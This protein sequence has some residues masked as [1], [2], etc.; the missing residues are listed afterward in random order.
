MSVEH[1]VT[2]DILLAIMDK[3]N[4]GNVDNV[5]SA[6]KSIYNVVHASVDPELNKGG[7]PEDDKQN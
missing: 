2:R 3:H 1:E 4:L 6:Y 5:T 7:F